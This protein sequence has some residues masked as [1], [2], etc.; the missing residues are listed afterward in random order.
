MMK[1]KVEKAQKD[2]DADKKNVED[3]HKKL[4]DISSPTE[5]QNQINELKM[6]LGDAARFIGKLDEARDLM[7]KQINK[8]QKVLYSIKTL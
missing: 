4:A 6:Q 5:L 7:Q 1:R 8:M 3:L 2:A